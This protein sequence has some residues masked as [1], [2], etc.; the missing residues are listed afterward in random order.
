MFKKIGF[1]DGLPEGT[2]LD[3]PRY[4]PVFDSAPQLKEVVPGGKP[5]NFRRF[6]S[7]GAVWQSG[8]G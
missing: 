5:P 2:N 1:E 3:R 4:N 8:G 7:S 6:G